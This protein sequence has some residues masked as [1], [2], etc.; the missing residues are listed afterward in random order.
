VRLLSN[1]CFKECLSLPCEK[2][3]L[4]AVVGSGSITKEQ[5]DKTM[6]SLIV[7]IRSLKGAIEEG[8]VHVGIVQINGKATLFCDSGFVQ[9]FLQVKAFESDSEVRGTS[10][11]WRYPCVCIKTEIKGKCAYRRY[12]R[13]VQRNQKCQ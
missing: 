9:R 7:M 3:V 10:S 5:F 12:F 8:K 6:Q 4:I 1:V 11:R 2:D 13:V